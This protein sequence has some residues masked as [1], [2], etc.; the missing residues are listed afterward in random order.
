[1]GNRT[2]KEVGVE[3]EAV[4]NWSNCDF[5]LILRLLI[6]IDDTLSQQICEETTDII[7]SL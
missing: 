1:M 5:L 6:I 2:I 4:A 7:E 3:E